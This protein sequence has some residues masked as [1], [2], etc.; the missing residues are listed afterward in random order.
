MRNFRNAAA[1]FLRLRRWDQVLDPETGRMFWRPPHT[2]GLTRLRELETALF[3]ELTWEY[4]R[5]GDIVQGMRELEA[6]AL[7][8]D[9]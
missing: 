4:D 1:R 2:R 7:D 6:I 5:A 9:E 8:H 3:H